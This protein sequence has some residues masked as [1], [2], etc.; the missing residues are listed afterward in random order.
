MV[1]W[2]HSSNKKAEAIS[3]VKARRERKKSIYLKGEEVIP[4]IIVGW[5]LHTG[6]GDH[7]AE[8]RNRHTTHTHEEKYIRWD[9]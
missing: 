2:S 4:L 1:L 7:G 3:H 5:L 9:R 6:D 8:R